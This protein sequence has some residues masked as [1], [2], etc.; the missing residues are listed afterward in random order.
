MNIV[1]FQKCIEA[2]Y[3]D[4]DRERGVDGTFRWFVEEVGELARAI[5]NVARS[6]DPAHRAN[7][8]EEFANVLAWLSTLASLTSVDLERA[9]IS[10]YGD[11][12]PKCRAT[13]CAC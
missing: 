3:L 2:I 12:C 7:L 10:E 9:A 5:R 8:E 13:P 6:D 1:E 11:G 4:R